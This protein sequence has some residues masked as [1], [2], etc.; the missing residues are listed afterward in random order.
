MSAA[1]RFVQIPSLSNEGRDIK[2]S[3]RTFAFLC[4]E[5]PGVWVLLVLHGLHLISVHR[6]LLHC[7]VLLLHYENTSILVS[8]S[9]TRQYVSPMREPTR[10]PM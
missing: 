4:L 1:L 7:G 9:M 10:E 3:V 6:G 5:G 8:K 2:T